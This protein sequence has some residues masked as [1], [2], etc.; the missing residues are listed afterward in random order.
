MVP[1]A[2]DDLHGRH[3]YPGRLHDCQERARPER[4]RG[5]ATA[6]GGAPCLGVAPAL[7]L[8]FAL[9]PLQ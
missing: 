8:G 2:G 5:L 6:P 9:R 1:T 3:N 4:A 7:V